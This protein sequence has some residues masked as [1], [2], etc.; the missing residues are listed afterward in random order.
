MKISKF[1]LVDFSINMH[2]V[3]WIVEFTERNSTRTMQPYVQTAIWILRVHN[4][5][6][7]LHPKGKTG[8]KTTLSD[9]FRRLHNI[10]NGNFNGEY[11][12]NE[13]WCRKSGN[14]IGN[15]RSLRIRKHSRTLVHKNMTIIL[16]TLAKYSASLLTIVYT[17]QASGIETWRCTANLN[18]TA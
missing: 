11:L 10:L 1:L 14:D 18:Q 12:R 4:L 16:P 6:Y 2:S 13:T 15:Y 7:P 3:V 5:G 9:G 17:M 8:P